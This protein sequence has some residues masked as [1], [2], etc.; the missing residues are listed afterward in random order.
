G[1]QEYIEG[2]ILPA[3]EKEFNVKVSYLPGVSLA[4]ISKL[5]AQQDS[6]QIDLACLDDGPREQAKE[7]GLLQATDPSKMPNLANVY[8]AAKMPDSIGVGLA[9]FGGGI[10]YNPEAYEKAKLAP[11]KSWNDLALPELKGHV[12]ADTI[13]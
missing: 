3:F 5:Q 9:V 11:P 1:I 13:T 8:D 7:M 12:I 6:P 2:D 10:L 4:T